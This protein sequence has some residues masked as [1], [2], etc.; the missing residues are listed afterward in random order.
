MKNSKITVLFCFHD[1]NKN[2]GGNRSL[3]DVIDNLLEKKNVEIL[4]AFPV[5]EGSAI[6]YLK[7]KNVYIVPFCYG[8]WDYHMEDYTPKNLYMI[9]KTLQKFCIYI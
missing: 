1:G 8:R 4:A 7:S 3:I 9:L 6:E 2:N 5:K